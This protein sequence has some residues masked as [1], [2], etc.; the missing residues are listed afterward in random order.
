V[1]HRVLPVKGSAEYVDDEP[2]PRAKPGTTVEYPEQVLALDEMETGVKVQDISEGLEDRIRK[3]RVVVEGPQATEEKE[4][5][6][7]Q[8]P[9]QV[10]SEKTYLKEFDT[11]GSLENTA[12][13]EAG[14]DWIRMTAEKKKPHEKTQFVGD[15]ARK[16]VKMKKAT[17]V[18]HRRME[19]VQSQREY[20][21]AKSRREARHMPNTPPRTEEMEEDE[22]RSRITQLWWAEH[23]ITS[24][25]TNL[26][27]ALIDLRRL[28]ATM[29]TAHTH[30]V[31]ILNDD[32]ET[33]TMVRIQRGM[34]VCQRSTKALL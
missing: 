31:A 5:E 27:H 7:L 26:D 1:E 24:V 9:M 20:K 33:V 3:A 4:E 30:E 25:H 13:K 11:D 16:Y 14:D 23:E 32:K 29:E 22:S 28:M 15:Q 18:R 8:D 34:K 10:E 21:K 6:E 12:M 2:P 19:A 17:Y